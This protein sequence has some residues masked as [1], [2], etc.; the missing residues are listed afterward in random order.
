[1]AF[2]LCK[3]FPWSATRSCA[4]GFDRENEVGASANSSV[5][6][7]RR[8]FLKTVFGA[9][10]WLVAKSLKKARSDVILP[11]SI[12]NASGRWKREDLCQN[13]LG[14]GRQTCDFCNGQ[15]SICF[16]NALDVHH[17]ECPNCSGVGSI[18]CPACIGLGLA[19]VNGILRDGKFH[20]TSNYNYIIRPNWL[21]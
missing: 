21:H 9:T 3:E 20:L 6:P 8:D 16:D 11:S 2:I 19:H 4:E 18:R 13:C 14:R 7:S 10:F 1:M 12:T 15:G 5:C 17:H